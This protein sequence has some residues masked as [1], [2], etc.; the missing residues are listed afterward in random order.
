MK[1]LRREIRSLKKLYK[2]ASIEE[3][4]PLEELRGTLR[5]ELKILQ[6]GEWHRRM[7]KKR[8]RKRANFLSNPFGFARTLLGEWRNGN[9]ETSEEEINNYLQD[10]MSDPAKELEMGINNRLIRQKP[11]VVQYD[12]RLP[13]WKEVVRAPWSASAPGPSGVPYIVYK[14]CKGILQILWKILRVIWRR[15]KIVEQWRFAEGVWIPKE[16]GSKSFD[17]FR[18][19]SLL[20][21][22][23]KI[24]FGLLSR[25]LSDFILGNGYIDTSV[26]KGWVAGMPGCLEHMGVLTQLLREAKENKEDLTVLWL[27]LANNY[28]SM[29]HKLV[30]E[31]LKRH[32]V[33]PSVCD[34]IADYFK[35]FRLRACSNTVTSGWQTLEKGII[36][37]CTMSTVLFTLTMNMLVKAAEAECRGALSRSGVRQ[38]PIRAYMDDLTVTTTSVMGGRWLLKGLERNMTCARMYFKPAKSRSLVLKKGKVMEKVRFT[39]TGETIPTL[40]EKPI[41]SLGKTFNSSLKDTAT[42]QKTIKDLEEWLTNIDQSGLPGRFKVLLFQHAVLPLILWPLLVYDI[43]ITTVE[44]K[45]N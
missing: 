3:R 21:T 10:T 15:G 33:L 4:Q 37:G 7:R 24:I 38:S 39:V 31:A 30:E 18:I 43:P 2:R 40:S 29:P 19:I 36:I 42:K 45:S 9:L 1:Y 32:H 13:T 5:G 35:N 6:R 27:D 34:L 28:G 26:Q 20:N 16:K 14:R 41:K 17:Q 11:P 23:S 22:E 25:R 8:S 12:C 44:R